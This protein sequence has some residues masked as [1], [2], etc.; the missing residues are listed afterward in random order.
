MAFELHPRLAAGTFQLGHESG[1]LVLLKN[2]AAFPWILIIPEVSSDKEDLH[3]LEEKQYHDVCALIRKVSLFM[4]QHFSPEKLN[5]GCI[6]N[7]VNQ[8]HIHVVARTSDDSAWPGTVWA[9]SEKKPYIE[10]QVA[11]IQQAWAAYAS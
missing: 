11:L 8:M 7:I 2:N 4:E 1:C 3:Q 9:S 6:G 5:V 10:D